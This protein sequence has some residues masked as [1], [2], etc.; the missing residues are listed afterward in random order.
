MA[1]EEIQYDVKVEN[2][3]KNYGGNAAVINGLY[4]NVKS[5]SMYVII[6]W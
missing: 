2:T 3:F 5:G 6:F 4:M 1:D